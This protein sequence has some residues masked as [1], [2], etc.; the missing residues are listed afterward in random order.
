MF[1]T[2]ITD[3]TDHA[4]V[5]ARGSWA[6]MGE[7][8][9]PASDTGTG[10]PVGSIADGIRFTEKDWANCWVASA[11]MRGQWLHGGGYC[12]QVTAVVDADKS[13]CEPCGDL[14]GRAMELAVRRMSAKAAKGDDVTVLWDDEHFPSLLHDAWRARVCEETGAAHKPKEA[15]QTAK[16]AAPL[17]TTPW[18]ARLIELAVRK[19]TGRDAAA[20]WS[21]RVLAD[22]LCEPVDLTWLRMVGVTVDDLRNA[23]V[24]VPR[25][26][27]AQARFLVSRTDLE[28]AFADREECLA[29]VVS[30]FPERG[31]VT[32][33]S[34]AAVEASLAGANEEWYDRNI[35]Q[36]RFERAT[37]SVRGARSICAPIG[38]DEQRAGSGLSAAEQAGAGDRLIRDDVDRRLRQMCEL[39]GGL[40]SA[41]Q[42]VHAEIG[43]LEGRSQGLSH[44]AVGVRY[45]LAVLRATRDVVGRLLKNDTDVS[46]LTLLDVCRGKGRRKGAHGCELV[47]QAAT[48]QKIGRA[49]GVSLS[50]FCQDIGLEV[51]ELVVGDRRPLAV[52]S[53]RRRLGAV[54]A[55][56]SASTASV[57]APRGRSSRT[58]VER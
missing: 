40:E 28:Q 48:A 2:D 1:I 22:K 27:A 20:E 35:G 19:A 30:L 23:G 41:L 24:A 53:V 58:A 12:P 6:Q 17:R 26:K 57:R 29:S 21:P 14:L 33:G 39:R 13:L 56:E 11:R 34:V 32:A 45:R 43:A 8:A 18:H 3:N 5:V 54:G 36:P 52:P 46:L 55:Y 9:D 15:L 38:R 4:D 42:E 50:E 51:A 47:R 31:D 10:H 7:V 37:A 16:W 25:E 44:G 49:L